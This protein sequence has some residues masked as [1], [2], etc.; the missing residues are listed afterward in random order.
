MVVLELEVLEISLLT[1]CLPRTFYKTFICL[2][3]SLI[4]V[5]CALICTRP[6]RQTRE[7][8]GLCA[9]YPGHNEAI[10]RVK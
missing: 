7:I 10:K 2:I 8:Y 4:S 3:P 9:T 5:C 1:L 6:P